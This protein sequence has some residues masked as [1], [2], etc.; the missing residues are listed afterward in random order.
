MCCDNALSIQ[1]TGF[2]LFG[3]LARSGG[4]EITQTIFLGSRPERC[5]CKKRQRAPRTTETQLLPCLLRGMVAAWSHWPD[6]SCAASVCACRSGTAH[7][8]HDTRSADS[9]RACA[10]LL[11]AWGRRASSC[12]QGLK[13]EADKEEK[14]WNVLRRWRAGEGAVTLAGLH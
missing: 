11:A 1:S 5:S 4:C 6:F 10:A 2:L 3:S 9:P 12:S 14:P 8:G 7:P 13:C